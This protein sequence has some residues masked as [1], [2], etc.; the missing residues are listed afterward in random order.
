MKIT[1]KRVYEAASSDDGQRVLIDRLWP[2]GVSKEKA[3][4]DLWLKELAPS[5]EL[6]K[7]VH[8]DREKRWAE[9]ERKYKAELEQHSQLDEL[10]AKLEDTITLVTSVK[11]PQQ[12][13]AAVFKKFLEG[14]KL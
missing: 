2:R 14:K 13:H 10:L 12:S 3:K 6:R 1:L 4:I 8:E 9:F 5:N 11:E 7:W